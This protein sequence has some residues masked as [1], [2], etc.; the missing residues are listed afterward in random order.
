MIHGNEE[1]D[2]QSRTRYCMINKDKSEFQ[3]S[4]DRMGWE[5]TIFCD[6]EPMSASKD[7]ISKAPTTHPETSNCVA[8]TPPPACANPCPKL[9]GD[10]SN[11]VQPASTEQFS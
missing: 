4:K 6:P 11:T 3:I 2:L 10:V 9:F 1:W 8:N 5:L 7:N